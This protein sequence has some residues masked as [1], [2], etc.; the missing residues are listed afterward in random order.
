MTGKSAKNEGEEGQQWQQDG[1]GQGKIQVKKIN[2]T[3][4]RRLKVRELDLIKEINKYMG[5]DNLTE[6]SLRFIHTGRQQFIVHLSEAKLYC[7]LSGC[8]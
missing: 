4:E 8:S 7:A 6:D 1:G 2:S 3:V 5:Q